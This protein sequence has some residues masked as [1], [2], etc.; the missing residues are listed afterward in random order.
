MT[1]T[2]CGRG[3]K[4]IFAPYVEGEH[5]MLGAIN[6]AESIVYWCDPAGYEEPRQF[7]VDTITKAFNKRN[8]IDLLAGYEAKEVVWKKIKC[9]MQPNGT[10]LCGYYIC[11]YMPEIIRGRYVS[12]IPNFMLKAPKS[13]TL[14]QIDEVKDI[15]A[16][17]ALQFKPK[18]SDNEV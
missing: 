4:L 14:E 1:C 11:R 2:G 6:P 7:F 15:W 5:W 18:I 10:V 13:Y 12:I 16:N 3:R 8:S 9:P 17:F